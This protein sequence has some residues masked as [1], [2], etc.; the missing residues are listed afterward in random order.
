MDTK[1]LTY[2]GIFIALG[3]LLPIAFHWVGL[4]RTFLPMH[5]PILLAGFIAGPLTAAV[6]GVITPLLS[7]VL[8]G[9]PPLAPTGLMM[10]VEL[11]IY[12]WLAG[13]AYQRYSLGKIPSLVIAILAGRLVYG[14]LM[15]LALPLF[16]LEAIHPLYP[17][18]A[19]LIGSLPGIILQLILVPATVGLLEHGSA[20]SIAKES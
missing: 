17:I 18:G 2:G 10:A 19:G 6:V 11:P 13:A 1:K 20:L 14:F 8:T 3:V 12:G 9:M 5:I 16:G 15:W 4:G 7:S